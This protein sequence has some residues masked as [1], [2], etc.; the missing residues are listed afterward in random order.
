M[1]KYIEKQR[2]AGQTLNAYELAIRYT[3][4]LVLPYGLGINAKAFEND[5]DEFL[6]IARGGRDSNS[7]ISGLSGL[8][9]QVASTF[10]N[11]F[12]IK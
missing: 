9:I 4:D 2:L 5:N 11:A 10:T 7:Y 1:T 8:L 3:I 6:K 12:K